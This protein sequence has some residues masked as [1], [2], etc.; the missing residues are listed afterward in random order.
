MNEGEVLTNLGWFYVFVLGLTVGLT[1]CTVTCLPY[2]GTWAIGRGQGAQAALLDTASFAFGKILAY[3]LLG[4]LAGWMGEALISILNGALGHWLI[5]IAAIFAGSWLALSVSN[6]IKPCNQAKRGQHT[7]PFILGFALG[8]TPCPPLGALV[9]ACAAL[10]SPAL[11]F[12]YGGIFGVGA[13]ITP[14]F[15]VIPLLANFGR[16]LQ[17]DR[18]WLKK[19]LYRGAGGVLIVIGLRRIF[20]AI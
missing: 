4:M 17:N 5:G 15:L 9:G 13:A 20:L 11:G 19:W 12:Y 18:E 10:G 7:S 3:A 16:A 1:A 6:P 2:L 8:F 14:L